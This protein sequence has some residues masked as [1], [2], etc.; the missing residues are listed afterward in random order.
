MSEVLDDLCS[1]WVSVLEAHH[2][3]DNQ[4][5]THYY[6]YTM[7][8]EMDRS[9]LA[10]AI[11]TFSIPVLKFRSTILLVQIG[12]TRNAEEVAWEQQLQSN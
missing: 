1:L 7:T 2:S 12:L 9:I 11:Q 4:T 10:K 8:I 3:L 6:V 5:S